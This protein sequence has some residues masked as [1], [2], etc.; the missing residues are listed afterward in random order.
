MKPPVQRKHE[1]SVRFDGEDQKFSLS[2]KMKNVH[3]VVFPWRTETWMFCLLSSRRSSASGLWVRSF[4]DSEET[5]SSVDCDVILTSGPDSKNL[6]SFSTSRLFRTL[7]PEGEKLQR[8]A[9]LLQAGRLSDFLYSRNIV[10]L[11]LKS[12]FFI[13]PRW[14]L[15]FEVALVHLLY[16]SIFTNVILIQCILL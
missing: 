13:K 16:L 7:H 14:S 6:Q 10:T 2:G 4:T 15:F 3:V 1:K 11:S 12:L 9:V 8:A 5:V